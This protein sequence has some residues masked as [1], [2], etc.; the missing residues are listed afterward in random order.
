MRKVLRGEIY[1]A[2][3]DPVIGSEEGG[4]R[5]VLVIQ[6]NRGTM[7]C[8]T[9]LISPL[10]RLINKKYNLYT[11]VHIEPRE[12]LKYDSV[13]L[14]EQIRVVE[15][16]RLMQYLGKITSAEQRLVDTAILNTF[17]LNDKE[18]KVYEK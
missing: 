4:I 10:T 15:K 12:Y 18:I 2:N 17:S 9:C 8:T 16:T 6:D 11:H 1:Y 7:N 3:L 5:P 13:I 14:L